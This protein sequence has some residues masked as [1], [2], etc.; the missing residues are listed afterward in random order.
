LSMENKDIEKLLEIA[1]DLNDR[2][3]TM[4]RKEAIE[5]LNRAGIVTKKGSFRD[6]SFKCVC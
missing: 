3:K 1:K 4:N 2:V 6:C 5:Y